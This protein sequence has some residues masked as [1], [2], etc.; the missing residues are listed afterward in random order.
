MKKKAEPTCSFK[1]RVMDKAV[2]RTF[3]AVG[4]LVDVESQSASDDETISLTSPGAPAVITAIGDKSNTWAA[5]ML[6]SL[7]HSNPQML[8]QE[9]YDHIHTMIHKKKK[10]KSK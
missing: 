9:G 1:D 10:H 5:D 2:H 7:H 3:N 8:S 4:E 6:D